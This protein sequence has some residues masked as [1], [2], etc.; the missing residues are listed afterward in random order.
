MLIEFI[1]LL[2]G[3]DDAA[4]AAAAAGINIYH[5]RKLHAFVCLCVCA[6][7]A[8]TSFARAA[9]SSLIHLIVVINHSVCIESAQR[10]ISYRN[11]T[12]S[13]ART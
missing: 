4:A 9:G 2:G 12:A 6:C 8:A 10:I 5:W 1:T 7:V 3:D 11:E 13:N